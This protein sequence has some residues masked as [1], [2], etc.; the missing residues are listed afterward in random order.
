MRMLKGLSRYS[1]RNYR[2]LLIVLMISSFLTACNAGSFSSCPVIVEY[3]NQTEAQVD[4]DLALLP[5]NSPVKDFM[6]DY[7]VL[8]NEARACLQ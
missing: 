8:R 5:P 4:H 6:K 7:S 3:S 1:R 2:R